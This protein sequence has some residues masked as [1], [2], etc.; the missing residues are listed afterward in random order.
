MGY[1]YEISQQLNEPIISEAEMCP[2]K[3]KG[4][5]YLIFWGFFLLGVECS[6]S[7][8]KQRYLITPTLQNLMTLSSNTA[9]LGINMQHSTYSVLL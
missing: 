2:S 5:F 4:I 7:F 9:K 8:T 1:Q 3:K 6:L